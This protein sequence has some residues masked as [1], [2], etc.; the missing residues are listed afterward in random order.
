LH[1]PTRILKQALLRLLLYPHRLIPGAM[2][3]NASRVAF[4]D[5]TT[6]AR[7]LDRSRRLAGHWSQHS[8]VPGDRVLIDLPNSAAFVEGRL[9]AILGGFVAVPIPP[10]SDDARLEW[11][12]RSC[13]TRACL[14]GRPEAV[15]GGASIRLDS[16][17][18]D[19]SAYESALAAATPLLRSPRIGRR[20]LM[21]INFTSGTTGEPKGVMCT[22]AGWGYSLYYS[23]AENR[24]PLGEGEV[25]LHAIPLATAGSALLLPAV[26]SG[27]KNLF[28]SEW[29][30]DAAAA[31]VERERVTRVFLTPT[32]LAEFVDAVR[33]GGRDVSSLRAVIYGTEGIPATRIRKAAGVLGPILQQGYGMAEALPPICLLH[34]DEHERA[35]QMGDEELLSSSGRPTGAVELR[36][37]DG[38]GRTVGPEEIGSIWLKGRTVSRGYWNRADLT[39]ASRRD[40]FYVTGD[41]G[42]LDCRGYLHVTGREGRIGSPPSARKLVE[43]AEGRPD[44]CLAWAAEARG[45]LELH[46]VAARGNALDCPLLLAEAKRFMGGE[47]DLGVTLHAEAPKTPSYKLN[48]T[49]T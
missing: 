46:L 35:V 41:L 14:G 44:V 3:R 26:L 15:P 27:A 42:Y 22:A 48:V 2:A 10:G 33:A 28:L 5:G 6:F 9:A 13:Q 39:A 11:I 43:W 21:T 1:R 25:F 32:M 30:A 17:S 29:D 18:G 45:C 34:P 4:S 36:V 12:A 37:C 38:K 49:G 16:G 24:V 40:G 20:H 31:L 23:L 19:C 47:E 7:L 8:L